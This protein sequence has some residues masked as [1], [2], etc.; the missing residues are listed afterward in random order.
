[1]AS[2]E[3][4]LSTIPWTMDTKIKSV[5]AISYGR[6]WHQWTDFDALLKTTADQG[7]HFEVTVFVPTAT[8][9]ISNCKLAIQ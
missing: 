4:I 5:L 7:D 8:I 6:S 9:S 3:T 2:S 1:M